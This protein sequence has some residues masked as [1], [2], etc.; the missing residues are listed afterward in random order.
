[1]IFYKRFV[2]QISWNKVMERYPKANCVPGKGGGGVVYK[3]LYWEV[4]PNSLP[5]CI[6]Y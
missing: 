4:P 2:R 6:P 3:V 1:M 5:F